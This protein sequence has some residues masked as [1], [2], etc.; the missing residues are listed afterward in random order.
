VRWREISL[1]RTER[2]REEHS[3][4]WSGPRSQEVDSMN[5][6]NRKVGIFVALVLAF[7]LFAAY[8]AAACYYACQ[9][10]S[11]GCE[12]CV[13]AGFFTGGYCQDSGS[14]GCFDV[15]GICWGPQ[16]PGKEA[17]VGSADVAGA[18]LNLGQGE[19]ACP[20]PGATGP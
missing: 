8:P 16:A 3:R 5:P 6:R 10:V 19:Q 9:E 11:P 1:L 2:D 14:C 17:A 7:A 12:R 13:Y 20:T 4:S 18:S 15:Q